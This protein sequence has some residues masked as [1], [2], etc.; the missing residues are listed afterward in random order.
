MNTP[1]E[2]EQARLE[3][4]HR[5]EVLDTAA[6]ETLDRITR[7]TAA[8]FDAPI[9]LISLVDRDRQWFKSCHGINASGTT[10][11]VA[12]CARTILLDTPGEVLVVEDALQNPEFARNPYVAGFP[13]VRFYAG[14][15]LRTPDGYHLGSLCI[16]DTRPRPDLSPQQKQ[17][18]T[19]LAATVMDLLLQR[20]ARRQMEQMEQK[21]SSQ[22]R[23]LQTILQKTQTAAWMVDLASGVLEV[24]DGTMLTELGF[25]DTAEA[26]SARVQ[27]EDLPGLMA[28]WNHTI[29]TGEESESRYRFKDEGQEHRW[30]SSRI[31][32]ERSP[33]GHPARI[34]GISHDV[35]REHEH[36]RQLTESETKLR[37]VIDHSVD[38]ICIKDL[39]GRYLLVN[40]AAC[41]LLQR[42]MEEVLGKIDHSEPRLTQFDLQVMQLGQPITYEHQVQERTVLTSKYPFVQDGQV[43]GVVGV[44]RDITNLKQMEQLLRSH[45]QT[46]EETVK[47]RTR[48]LEI[49]NAEL[50]HQAIHD[51]LTGLANRALLQD[52]LSQV[53]HRMERHPDQQ[54]AVMFLDCDQFK[55]INDTYGHSVGDRF[56][57]AFSARI[58]SAVRPYDTVARFG[59]DEFAVLLEGLQDAEQAIT[60]GQRLQQCLTEPFEVGG[61]HLHASSSIGLVMGA[62]HYT[63]HDEVLR[64]AD[65][66][67]YHAKE[68]GLGQLKC[69]EDGMRERVLRQSWL[70]NEL[71][72]ALQEEAIMA[73]YQPIVDTRTGQVR[74]FEALARWK[75]PERG[76]IS[77]A[78]FIPVA[79]DAGLI[80]DLD[81]LILKQA[82]Q[83]LKLWKAEHP[84]LQDLYLNVNMSSVQFSRPE[85]A[86][87][88]QSTLQ[89]TQSEGIHLH[90]EITES[91]MLQRTQMV[92]EHLQALHDLG[93]KL[94]I[95]DFGTGYSSLGYLPRFGAS[96]LKI[97]RSFIRDILKAPQQ[98]E[99]VRTII[100]M[101]HNL[102]MTVVAEGVETIEQQQWLLQ[103]GCDYLQGFLFSPPVEHSKARS[104]L[105]ETL[106]V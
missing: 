13:N 101:A 88:V 61:K 29:A 12:F 90:L 33:E 26:F 67:M 46:L 8:L 1:L 17:Q 37:A 22:Q 71:R 57:Q 99:L 3:A 81:R 45:N 49:L 43:R 40:K 15:P 85:F 68:S 11:D 31:H 6:E 28:S 70:E 105:I 50:Q 77:P 39:D 66:A 82:C 41:E 21:V 65:T 16:M 36:A 51:P 72:L 5:L 78:E 80:V 75:H 93:V 47:S 104:F 24:Q 79:E 97:D 42:P 87:V 18:L 64:D 10:R 52:R 73:Y 34:L 59:G 7:V 96:A 19:D 106:E 9:S 63:H 56:L 38:A 32:L 30:Y 95:D 62:A 103:E 25:P 102:G 27:E 44:S 23:R 58:S 48:E 92:A 98:A 60:I 84:H 20:Q 76:F 89:E 35:T 55:R 86:A 83:Q 69:F 54:Y 14:A 4:L 53:M 91:L 94:H 2:H 100:T 74:G